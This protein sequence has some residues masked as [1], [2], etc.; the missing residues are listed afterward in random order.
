[1]LNI[2]IILL[3]EDNEKANKTEKFSQLTNL[4]QWND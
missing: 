1:M 2:R 4:K 3:T